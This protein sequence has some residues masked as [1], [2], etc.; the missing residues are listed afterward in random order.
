MRVDCIVA[1]HRVARRRR[2]RDGLPRAPRAADAR[3]ARVLDQAKVRELAARDAIVLVCGRYEGFDERVRALRRRGDLARRLRDDRRRGGRDGRR[4]RLRAPAARACSATRRRPIDESHSADT[5]GLLEYPQYTRPAE[6]RGARV[7]EVLAGGQ[8]RRDRDGG[9]GSRRAPDRRARRP[10]LVADASA[11]ARARQRIMRRLAIALV[12]HP[13]LDA[14]G[15]D[16]HDGRS[17][18]STC[19]ISRASAR[20]YGVQ[21]LLRRASDRGAARAR[22]ADPRALDERLERPADPRSARGARLAARSSPSLDA[23]VD[24]L[25]GREAVE[26]W[27]TAARELGPTLPFAAARA[28]LEA[29]RASRCCSCFGTGWGLRPPSSPAPTPAS[30]RS[31]PASTDTTTSASAPPAPS[32]SIACSARGRANAVR[33]GPTVVNVVVVVDV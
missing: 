15:R 32:P 3:R 24:A 16:G 29:K 21:R 10:D 14:P 27:A 18:T 25:G 22:R 5:G 8:P 11:R 30:S 31:A 13:V 19:T 28:R 26:I 12:H 23:G 6:F 20:T 33:L 1:G 7:P 17:P 9:A 4:R 2:D